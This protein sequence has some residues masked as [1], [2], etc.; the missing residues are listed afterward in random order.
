MMSHTTLFSPCSLP[1]KQVLQ[2]INQS[3]TTQP[4]P[5]KLLTTLEVCV[6]IYIGEVELLRDEKY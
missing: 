2:T 5:L 6:Y 3:N 1:N 4:F